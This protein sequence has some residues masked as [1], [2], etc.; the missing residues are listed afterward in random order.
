MCGRFQLTLPFSELVRLYNLTNSVNL[1]PRYNLAPTQDAAVVRSDPEG[2]RRLDLMRW[3]LVPFW[4]KDAKVGY[5]MFNAM[6]E[7]VATKPAFREPFKARRCIVPATGFYE[8][9]KLDAKRKQAYSIRMADDGL[10]AFAGLWDRWHD[11]KSGERVLSFSIVTCEPNA[12]CAPIH[13]RMPVIL[14]KADYAAWLA[15]TPASPT[16]LHG[17]LR[18]FPA[19][20][21]R[22]YAIGPRIGNVKNDDPSVLEPAAAGAGLPLL[23]LA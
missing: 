13:D 7:T 8:W 18:P 15:E 9:Q 6:A 16:A 3:G 4:A 21:M 23:G 17:L 20:R 19:D 12:L 14:D 10:I 1:R 5:A 11:P 2:G 22:A